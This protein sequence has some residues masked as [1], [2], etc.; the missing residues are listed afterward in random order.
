MSPAGEGVGGEMV[1]LYGSSL[2]SSPA[3][4]RFFLEPFANTPSLSIPA[5][6][7]FVEHY[8]AGS[9]GY[10]APLIK[11]GFFVIGFAD[12]G[13]QQASRNDFSKYDELLAAGAHVV[14]TEYLAPGVFRDGKSEY[15]AELPCG[16]ETYCVLPTNSTAPPRRPL[17]DESPTGSGITT[18]KPVPTK[19]EPRFPQG[20][21]TGACGSHSHA[22]ALAAIAALAAAFLWIL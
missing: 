4:T 22:R 10:V 1:D 8:A 6:T 18:I 14:L 13:G 9:S 5:D 12:L 11:E 2:A 20:F 19:V 3:F 17:A 21:V 16:D 15:K 7:V